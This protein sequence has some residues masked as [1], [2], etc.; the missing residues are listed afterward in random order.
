MKKRYS[1][2]NSSLIHFLCRKGEGKKKLRRVSV[3]V[4]VKKEITAR[5]KYIEVER[6][7][8]ENN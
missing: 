8:Q 1:K 4:R 6:F 5:K 7:K 2:L 3:S